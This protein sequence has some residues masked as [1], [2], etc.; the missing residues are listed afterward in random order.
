MTLS[1]RGGCR[2]MLESIELV[3]ERRH[4]RAAA[5]GEHRGKRL[6]VGAA[7]FPCLRSLLPHPRGLS[8][9]WRRRRARPPHACLVT[10]RELVTKI[11]ASTNNPEGNRASEW[12][13]GRQYTAPSCMGNVSYSAHDVRP[14]KKTAHLLW[15]LSII[16]SVQS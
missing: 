10:R 4:T 3:M 6:L 15:S 5:A 11:D 14:R 8:A 7:S 2:S 16:R 12:P 1:C 9:V 13:D